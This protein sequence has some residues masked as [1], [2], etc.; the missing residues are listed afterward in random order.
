MVR[1]PSYEKFARAGSAAPTGEAPAPAESLPPP[2]DSVQ[3]PPMSPGAGQAPQQT[4]PRAAVRAWPA[5]G[6][7]AAGA[8]A[9]A[10]AEEA[11]AAA[12]AGVKSV[13]TAPPSSATKKVSRASP[14]RPQG[15]GTPARRGR[16][17]KSAPSAVPA[18]ATTTTTSAAAGRDG[19]IIKSKTGE[20]AKAKRSSPLAVETELAPAAAV[21][22]APAPATVPQ[23]SSVDPPS[24]PGRPAT[25]ALARRM[26]DIEVIEAA[27]L[28]GTEKGGVSNPR[29]DV[30][31]VDLGGRAIRSEGVKHTRVIKGTTNPV[32]NYQV[33]FGQRANLSAPVGGN[34]PTLRIQVCVC[35][36]VCVCVFVVTVDLATST[37]SYGV[38]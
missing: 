36:C 19:N 35:V 11:A 34:M 33:S 4:A 16:N 32:W 38:G 12:G 7:A 23:P 20:A 37:S 21:A 24:S 3:P 5:A 2:V 30:L 17:R 13:A 8:E 22:P 6:A 26:L 18:A 14:M 29:A 15:K 28:L 25:G 9:G 10:G 27:G 1:P 31:L